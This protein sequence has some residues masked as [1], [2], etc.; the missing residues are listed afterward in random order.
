M[1]ITAPIRRIARL[2]PNATAIIRADG[3]SIS[4]GVLEHAIDRMG[5]YAIRLGLE[6]GDIAG[7]RI[8]GPDESLGL[9]LA[10]GLARIGVASAEPG[11]PAKHLRLRFQAGQASAPGCVSFDASWMPREPAPPDHV[12][13]P[14]H[15]DPEAV[16]RILS[17]SG[18]TGTPKHAIIT[19]AVNARRVEA[20]CLAEGGGPDVRIIG[21]GLGGSWGSNTALRTLWGGGTIVLS[22]PEHAAEAISRHGVTAISTSPAAL[23]M[24]LGALPQGAGP[25]ASLQRIEMSGSRLPEALQRLAA[26]RL[27]GRLISFFGATETSL[28]ASAPVDAL[29]SRPGAVGLILPGVE[30]EALDDAQRPL[31][32]G[33]EGV[34]RFRSDRLAAG[35]LGEADFST[36][37][38]QDG[39]FHSS[40]IGTVWPDGMLTINGRTTDVINAG[41]VKVHPHVIESALMKLPTVLDAAAFGVPDA[42]GVTRIWAAIVA[43][44]RIDDAVLNAFCRHALPGIA[45]HTILQMKALPRNQN[46][47]LRR[48]QLVDIGLHATSRPAEASVAHA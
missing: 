14:I 1:N 20:T 41:G 32:P 31:P 10:L 7:L 26:E 38:F 8:D 27:G 40:D 44:S 48:D 2:H 23:R 5:G 43:R 17:S 46:G 24:I 21:V 12:P 6:P 28:T 29:T 35:Y 47:K 36:E 11:V 42:L 3:S 33:Q 13:L 34:L 25:F 19:H 22:N 37:R 39:W 18:T 4:Y 9:T 16:F 15:P 45:P 30:V